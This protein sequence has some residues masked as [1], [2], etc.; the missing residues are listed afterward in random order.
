MSSMMSWQP[1]F[2]AEALHK[3]EPLNIQSVIDGGKAHGPYLTPASKWQ[4]KA[5][6]RWEVIALGQPHVSHSGSRDVSHL[7]HVDN[8]GE[9]QCIT[10][11]NK[12]KRWRKQNGDLVGRRVEY[13]W[14]I[15]GQRDEGGLNVYYTCTELSNDIFKDFIEGRKYK[16]LKW[17]IS[18]LIGL[19]LNI[20][21]NGKSQNGK[22]F[23]NQI[24]S[25]PML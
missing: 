21:K 5:T 8:H 6:G 4:Q 3:T 14:E 17:T 22:K 25:D 13:G 24:F 23:K 12:T 19:H 11:Q 15:K 2:P 1:P 16:L 10:K 20:V 9:P 18:E 7:A